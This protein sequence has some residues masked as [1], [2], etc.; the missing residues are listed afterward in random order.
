MRG[1]KKLIVKKKKKSIINNIFC[2]FKN[3]FKSY[4]KILLN[5]IYVN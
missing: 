5:I 1:D 4:L 3:L 2:F